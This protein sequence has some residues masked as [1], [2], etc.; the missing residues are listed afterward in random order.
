[1]LPLTSML[2]VVAKNATVSVSGGSVPVSLVSEP[3]LPAW[4]G[5][6]PLPV[7]AAK[8]RDKKAKVDDDQDETKVA[9]WQ[10]K[11]IQRLFNPTDSSGDE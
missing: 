3:S 11:R 5:F 7:L 8:K 4:Q 2:C 9:D 6:D 1:M 10:E